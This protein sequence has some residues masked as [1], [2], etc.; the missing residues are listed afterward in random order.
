MDVEERKKALRKLL[1]YQ[2]E[3]FVGIFKALN[4]IWH[5]RFLDPLL[6]E[7]LPHDVHRKICPEMGVPVERVIA[8]EGTA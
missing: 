3:D 4:G 6:H 2:R 1:P 5:I 8:R 7:F